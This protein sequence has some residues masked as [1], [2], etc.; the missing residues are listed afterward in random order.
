MRP[1]RRAARRAPVRRP[2]PLSVALVLAGLLGTACGATAP[3]GPGAS[4]TT[5]A[6]VPTTT[7]VPTTVPV[8]TTVALYFLRGPYLGVAHR[9][10][11]TGST[12]GTSALTALLDGPT[13]IEA[14]AGLST[15]VPAGSALRGLTIS[16]GVATVD[17]NGAFAMPGA[18]ESELGRVAQVVY[19]LTQFP[20]VQSVAFEIGGMRPT[21]FASGAVSLRRPLGRTDVLAALP[22][23]LVE[24]PAVGDSLHGSL[25]LKGLANVFEAQFNMQL[26]DAD[27]NVLLDH[28]VHASAGS[29]TWGTFDVTFPVTVKAP[30][31]TTLRVFD[32][33]A[34][35]GS[36]M[37]EIDLHLPAGP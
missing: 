34:K 32:V 28:P 24:S 12:P 22:A 2:V 4:S 15:A 7:G 8:S 1:R 19:T 11:V 6:T 16:G 37:D 9:T 13:G 18:P 30:V 23:I 26:V 3:S 36:P 31:M 33:S 35:D 21:M 27:G 5:T 17:L 20:S 29:G 14:G 10:L 25:R